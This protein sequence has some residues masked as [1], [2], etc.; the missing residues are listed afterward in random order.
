M[1]MLGKGMDDYDDE[2]D[3]D[4]Y[5]RH[6][7]DD[8]EEEQMDVDEGNEMFP[9]MMFRFGKSRST[10]F[11]NNKEESKE[12]RRPSTYLDRCKEVGRVGPKVTKLDP[13]SAMGT[14]KIFDEATNSCDVEGVI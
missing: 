2:D 12:P 14:V 13:S 4:E 7:D 1:H 6:E 9:D 3:M 5:Q 11:A 10:P 8:E